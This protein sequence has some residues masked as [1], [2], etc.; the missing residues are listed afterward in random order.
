MEFFIGLLHVT[1]YFSSDR[2]IAIELA[3]KVQRVAEIDKLL[4]TFKKVFSAFTIFVLY[5]KKGCDSPSVV[6]LTL[7]SVWN[8]GSVKAFILKHNT[9]QE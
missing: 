3:I 5:V 2:N 7:Q 4:V 9:C 1:V 6:M 8:N